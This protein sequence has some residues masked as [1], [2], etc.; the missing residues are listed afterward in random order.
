MIPQQTWATESGAARS[1]RGAVIEKQAR[2]LSCRPGGSLAVT[3]QKQYIAEG[4]TMFTGNIIDEL[5]AAVQRAEGRA[6][7]QN[8]QQDQPAY[9]I[10]NSEVAL[11]GV[12]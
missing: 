12:A 1:N 11:V 2:F 9:E 4:A 7:T 6:E 10:S 8:R 3:S 5:I